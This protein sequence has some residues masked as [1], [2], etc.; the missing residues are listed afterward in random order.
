MSI[1]FSTSQRG[2]A[3]SAGSYFFELVDDRAAPAPPGRRFVERRDV[4]QVQQQPRAL[5]MAQ[6]LVAEAG[7]FGG[8]L[9]QARECRR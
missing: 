7:A 4:D 8:A 2:L 3:D 9:D 5:Q 1:L 6:E